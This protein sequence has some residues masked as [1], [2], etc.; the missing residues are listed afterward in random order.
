MIEPL[1]DGNAD[2]MS[3]SSEE[4][5]VKDEPHAGATTGKGGSEGVGNGDESSMQS[6]AEVRGVEGAAAAMQRW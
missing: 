2:G 5:V 3:I 1:S 4:A 6:G